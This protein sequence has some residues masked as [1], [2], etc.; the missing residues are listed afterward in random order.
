MNLCAQ[1]ALIIALAK[2]TVSASASNIEC[3]ACTLVMSELESGIAGVDKDKKIGVGSFRID[4]HGNQGGLNQIPYAR[5]ETHIHELLENVCEKSQQYSLVVH[6]T[7]GKAVFVRKDSTHLPG[8][9]DRSTLARLNN[10][11]SD[12]LDDYE[13]EVIKFL[14]TE[15]ED[16]V[17]DF[18][19]SQIGKAYVATSCAVIML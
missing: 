6:P 7:T 3:G 10:A 1:I 12:F 14:A 17:R 19:Y 2:G 16:S 15:H 11:C 18:C 4:S 8:E 13:E 5:S 9:N